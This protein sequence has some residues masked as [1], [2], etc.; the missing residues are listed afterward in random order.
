MDNNFN[1]LKSIEDIGDVY[2]HN[3]QVNAMSMLVNEDFKRGMYEIPVAT[4]STLG[5]I[6]IGDG[7]SASNDGT[8]SVNVLTNDSINSIL[9]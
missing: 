6:K 3:L 7:I 8:T 4:Q 9:I 2:K 5:G 1:V